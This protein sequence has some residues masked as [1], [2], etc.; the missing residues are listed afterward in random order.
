MR[1]LD[2]HG[3]ASLAAVVR[4]EAEPSFEAVLRDDSIDAVIVCTPNA[5]HA[6]QVR[7]ALDAGKHVAVEFPLA[8]NVDQ[9]R[10][11]FDR[12]REQQRVLHVEHIELL[13]PAQR[14]QRERVA[15][16]GRP[17][18]G[19]L[20]FQAG[21]GGWIGDDRLAGTPP[22]RAL[23]RLHRLVDLFGPAHVE[24]AALERLSGGYQLE[25]RLAFRNGGHTQLTES[26]APD[27]ARATRWHIPCDA[28]TLDDPPA[29]AAEG[30]FARDLRCFLAR[31][32]DAAPSYVSEL[33]ILHA[34]DL[35]TQAERGI[36][37]L[38]PACPHAPREAR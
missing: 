16:L 18:G 27:L 6:E 13:S 25:L 9:A 24:Q 14:A 21:S 20:A 36:G 32:R 34:L 2:G 17:R 33:R 5:L 11:L 38:S 23:A 26:R 1:A 22:L 8:P 12:A 37:G 29:T 19:S 3:S 7:R 35:V 30:L 31:I 15:S 4:R 28:G 10:A